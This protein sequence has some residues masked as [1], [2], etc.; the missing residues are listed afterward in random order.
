[1]RHTIFSFP[2][3]KDRGLQVIIPQS[4]IPNL[5]SQTIY[6]IFFAFWEISPRLHN[7]MLD[8]KMIGL[9][10]AIKSGCH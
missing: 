8:L 5:K 10:H 1:M 6:L 9:K 7:K 4:P 3:L 2:Y